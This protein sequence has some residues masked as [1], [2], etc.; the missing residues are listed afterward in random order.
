[1]PTVAVNA[2]KSPVTK[3]SS[4]IATATLPNICKMPPP[5]PPFAPTPL[6]NIGQSGKQPKGYTTTV[7]VEGQ[8]VAVRGASFGSTGDIASKATGGGIVSSNAEGPTT[9]LAPGAL[10]VQF[11][12]KNV[13]LLGDQMLNNCGPA[14]TPANSATM[15]GVLHGPVVMQ[16]ENLGVLA[17]LKEICDIRCDCKAQGAKKVQLCIDKEL[18]ARDGASGFNRR[19]RS[20]VPYNMKGKPDPTPYMSKKEPGRQTRNWRIKGSRRPDAVIVNNP[21]APWVADN[22]AALVECK[23]GPDRYSGSQKS[24][25][26]KIAGDPDKVVDLDDTNCTCPEDRDPEP[27][28][29]PARD[30]AKKKVDEDEPMF[31]PAVTKPVAA[32]VATLAAIGV[33]VLLAP[34]VAVAAAAVGVLGLLGVGSSS[35]EGGS[36]GV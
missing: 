21:S 24:D 1:M 19:T 30:G 3:G 6:P 35:S 31:S 22:I 9:F 18:Y 15:A 36:G 34:E 26:E 10:N 5:P 16:A 20:E 33:A 27:V 13:Q 4:S 29:S 11:E 7:K 17:E 8:P 14:G 32:V 23:W 12:G 2:P 28:P 25:Y